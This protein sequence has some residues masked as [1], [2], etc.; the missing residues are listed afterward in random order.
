MGIG[1]G[2]EIVDR[3]GVHDPLGADAGFGDIPIAVN[4]SAEQFVGGSFPRIL[5]HVRRTYG[6]TRDALQVELTESAMMRR[7]DEVRAAIDDLHRDG[8]C[9][10]IDDFGTGFSSMVYLR[11]LA[12]DFLK[13]DRGFVQDVHCDPR[14]AAICVATISLAHGLG[15]EVIAEGVEEAAQ[16]QWLRDHGC[17]Q[18]Q[19]FHMARPE[20]LEALIQRLRASLAA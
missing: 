18:A 20:P 7:P 13:L 9:I 15:L 17:D 3:P 12:V 6:L 2:E 14:N 5:R 19:G 10:A 1:P 8:V 16:L 4:A 11:D